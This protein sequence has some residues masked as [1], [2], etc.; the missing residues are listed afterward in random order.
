MK[1]LIRVMVDKFNIEDAITLESLKE[2]PELAKEKVV[3][4]ETVFEESGLLELD[5]RKLELFLNGVML[6]F[7]KPDGVYRVYNNNKFIGLGNI[8]SKLLKRDVI[9]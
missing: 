1:E 6:T 2:N 3:T 8:K 9:L 4:I 5:N 7:E